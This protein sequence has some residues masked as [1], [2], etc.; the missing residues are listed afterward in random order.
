MVGVEDGIWL[1][2]AAALPCIVATSWQSLVVLGVLVTCLLVDQ[3]QLLSVIPLRRK[4]RLGTAK[5][6]LQ[7]SVVM[8][9]TLLQAIIHHSSQSTMQWT[10]YSNLATLLVIP[11][12]SISFMLC[13]VAT[14]FD[15]AIETFFVCLLMAVWFLLV[16][17][18]TNKFTKSFTFGEL[19]SVSLVLLIIGFEYANE[20]YG[21]KYEPNHLTDASFHIHL[22]HCRGAFHAM[23][24]HSFVIIYKWYHGG[25]N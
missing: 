15:P 11:K 9:L 12:Y 17:I 7:M 21:R 2:L 4:K 22:W 6:G 10:T 13:T 8:I 20:M 24:L 1:T 18:F 19:Q 16:P 14:I 25:R 5:L 3:G 23:L